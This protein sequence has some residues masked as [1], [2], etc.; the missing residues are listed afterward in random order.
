MLNLE[1]PSLNLTI[2]PLDVFVINV[3]FTAAG[4]GAEAF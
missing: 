2:L 1:L 3:A 4:G